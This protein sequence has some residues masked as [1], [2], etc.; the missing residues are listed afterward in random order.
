MHQRD[1]LRM[2]DANA[3]NVALCARRR[4][5]CNVGVFTGRVLSIIRGSATAINGRSEVLRLGPML[6]RVVQPARAPDFYVAN[7]SWTIA[8]KIERLVI[9]S[10]EGRHLGKSGIDLCAKPQRLA[11]L[12]CMVVEETDIK[13]A[14]AERRVP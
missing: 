13:I 1:R 9:G 12:F 7:A 11:P 4:A 8:G 5:P 14:V 3:V 10:K 2:G 6:P